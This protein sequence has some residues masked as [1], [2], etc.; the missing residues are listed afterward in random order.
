MF[1]I[2]LLLFV[3]IISLYAQEPP[4]EMDSTP[5]QLST[6]LKRFRDR[7]Q[8]SRRMNPFHFSADFDGDGRFDYVALI[9]ERSSKKEGFA[10][11]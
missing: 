10:V 2:F 8:I 9:I 7:Y 1:R 6:C 5:K 3:T 4:G 11:C